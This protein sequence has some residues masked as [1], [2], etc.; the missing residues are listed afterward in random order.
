MT[1]GAGVGTLRAMAGFV[2]GHRQRAEQIVLTRVPRAVV[3][4]L[5]ITWSDRSYEDTEG[6]WMYATLGTRALGYLKFRV[7]VE[8]GDPR[9]E[10]LP[11]A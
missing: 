10:M 8:G 6:I 7:R 4:F 1:P 9:V 3:R 11:V 5:Q 2:N